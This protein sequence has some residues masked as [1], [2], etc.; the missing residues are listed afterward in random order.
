MH[1]RC[2]AIGG[3]RANRPDLPTLRHL[4]PDSRRRQR[5]PVR[6]GVKWAAIVFAVALV[7]AQLVRPRHPQFGK[8]PDLYPLLRPE[9]R[10]SS[11]DVERIRAA[12]RHAAADAKLVSNVLH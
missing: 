4:L 12:A 3:D 11:T 7:A 8:M 6:K 2:P 9:T 5:R 1:T 10:L